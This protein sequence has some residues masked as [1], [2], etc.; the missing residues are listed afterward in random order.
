MSTLSG[1]VALVTGA[2][3][4]VGQGVALELGAQGATVYI[5]GRTVDESQAAVALPGTIHDTAAAVDQLGGHGIAIQCDHR[6]DAQVHA[7]F[8][9][10]ERERGRLDILVNNAWAGYE[11]YSDNRHFPPLTPFWE[12]PITFW[13][14]NIAGVRWAYVAS[15]FAAPIMIRQRSGLIVNISADVPGYNNPAYNIAKTA[16]DRLAR[17]M[18]H[19]LRP[20][21]VAVVVLYPGLVRTEL[22]LQN[23]QYFDMSNAESPQFTGRAVAALAGEARVIDKTGQALGVAALAQEYNFDD[24]DGSRPRPI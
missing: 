15:A 9:Q 17:E 23:A 10:I 16:T 21:Q 3:R 19:Q 7:V 20:H 13:D 18:A 4:G 11:G 24:V 5:T 2:S 1:Q 22:V 12:K 8:T 14:E 6:D